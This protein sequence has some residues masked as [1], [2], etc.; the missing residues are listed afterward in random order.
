MWT[1][2]EPARRWANLYYGGRWDTYDAHL[3]YIESVAAMLIAGGITVTHLRP[4]TGELDDPRGACIYLEVEP[5]QV[6][7]FPEGQTVLT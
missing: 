5:H 6:Q 2:S 7:Y 1:L 3:P 4:D